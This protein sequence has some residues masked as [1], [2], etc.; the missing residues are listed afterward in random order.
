MF[1]DLVDEIFWGA[2]ISE[3][4]DFL[5]EVE[6]ITE[7]VKAPQTEEI[8]VIQSQ[9]NL[10]KKKIFEDTDGEYVDFVEL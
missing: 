2:R 7:E 9:E 3:F 6:I 1:S 10:S 4:V 5:D 8:K